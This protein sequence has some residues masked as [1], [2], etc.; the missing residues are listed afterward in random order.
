MKV[1]VVGGKGFYGQ[2]VVKALSLLSNVSIHIAGRSVIHPHIR[3]DLCDENS[4]HHAQGFDVVINASDSF[5]APPQRFMKYCLTTGTDYFDMGAIDRSTQSLLNV[6]TDELKG[7]GIVGVG[8]FPGISTLLAHSLCKEQHSIKSLELAIRL[9]PLSGAGA[10]N[11]NLMTK[12]LTIP[13]YAIVDHKVVH[14]RP[15]G[16]AKTFTFPNVGVH[17][18]NQVSLADTAL[19]HHSTTASNIATYLAIKPSFLRYNFSLLSL[20]YEYMGPFKKLYLWSIYQSLR[21]IRSVLFKSKSTSIQ[22]SVVANRGQDDELCKYLTVEDGQMATA[23]A[24]A[25]TLSLWQ[26]KT[27]MMPGVYGFSEVFEFDVFA[28]RWFKITGSKL[29]I[30]SK[31]S[32]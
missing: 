8:I 20:V 15:V 32:L 16:K 9:S 5:E 26:E 13:S 30:D 11:C 10:G 6:S 3:L 7:C 23:F 27:K 24:V 12:M 14:D 28:E 21:L 19:L 1:L 18:A 2:K 31:I 17:V 29:Q 25:V 4:F 22:F